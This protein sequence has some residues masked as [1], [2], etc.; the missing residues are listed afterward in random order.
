VISDPNTISQAARRKTA[1]RRFIAAILIILGALCGLLG[2]VLLIG[3]QTKPQVRQAEW[4]EQEHGRYVVRDG[5]ETSFR[6][7]DLHERVLAAD[8]PSLHF[9]TNQDFCVEAWIKAYPVT[10]PWTR[11]LRAWIQAHPA[12]A[13]FVPKAARDWINEHSVDNDFGVTPLV[14]KHQTP[15][16]IEAVGFQLYLDFGRLACQLAQQPMRQLGFQNFV[17]PGPNLLDGRWHYVAM[18]VQRTSPAGGKL[19]VDARKVLTFDPTSEAGDLSNLQPLR[20]GNHANPN[21]RCI[22]KG[23]IDDVGFYRRAL[24][25]EEIAESYRSGHPRR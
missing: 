14:D 21:L 15:S 16:S 7:G 4:Q 9:G 19:Y 6:F 1:L 17:S 10:S 5:R 11:R 24:P 13:R 12:S 2:F 25:A 20:V 22:F 3:K 8:S 18:S 23:T